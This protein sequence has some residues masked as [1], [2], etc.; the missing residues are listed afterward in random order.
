MN[1]PQTLLKALQEQKEQR[2]VEALLIHISTDQVYNGSR[3]FWQEGCDIDP[4]NEYGRSKALAE[5]AIRTLWP[6]HCIL[7]SSIIYG[8]LPAVPVAR[9]LFVQFVV[10]PSA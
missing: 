6:K 3:S 2:N 7:R 5:T 4:V 9:A 10:R 8:P 1:I